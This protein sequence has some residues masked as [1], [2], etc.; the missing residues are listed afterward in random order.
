M[1]PERNKRDL[2]DIPKEV[3]ESLQFHFV[4]EMEQAIDFALEP[5]PV[6]TVSDKGELTN[7]S[8]ELT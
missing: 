7:L 8:V 2:E 4:K 3:V 6:A 1:L 5:Q